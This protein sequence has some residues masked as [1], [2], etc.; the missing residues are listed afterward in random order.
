MWFVSFA[1]SLFILLTL[2]HAKPGDFTP[3]QRM[4][5]TVCL[6]YK[7][8]VYAIDS[9]YGEKDNPDKN[10]LTWLVSLSF[11]L[12]GL[13]LTWLEGYAAREVP[14]DAPGRVPAAASRLP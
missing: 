4:P 7:D 13:H 5:A 9:A 2:Q 8:G 11:D 6:N 14:D 3:G 12:K 1:A 10:V